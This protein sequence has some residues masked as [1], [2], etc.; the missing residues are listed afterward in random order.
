[1]RHY[2]VYYLVNVKVT[3]YFPYKNYEKNQKLL[4]SAGGYAYYYYRNN[5]AQ[6]TVIEEENHA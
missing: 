3:N 1:M 5:N 2:H 6:S 4:D